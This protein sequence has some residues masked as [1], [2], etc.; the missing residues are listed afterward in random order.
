[1]AQEGPG[2]SGNHKQ[3][4]RFLFPQT[5]LF[6]IYVSFFEYGNIYIFKHLICCLFTRLSVFLTSIFL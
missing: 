5:Y 6:W 3:P 1:M 2:D 4:W